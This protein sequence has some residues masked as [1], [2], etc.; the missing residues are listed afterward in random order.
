MKRI[1]AAIFDR[2]IGFGV[3]HFGSVEIV[4][5]GG[6]IQKRIRASFPLLFQHQTDTFVTFLLLQFYRLDCPTSHPFEP[7]PPP[8]SLLPSPVSHIADAIAIHYTFFRPVWEISYPLSLPQQP[9]PLLTV[10]LTGHHSSS[11]GR[12]LMSIRN[13]SDSE[14]LRDGILSYFS[15][16]Y[17]WSLQ[18]AL[19]RAWRTR[20][21]KPVHID[22]PQ[23]SVCI[24]TSFSAV[25][26]SLLSLLSFIT[27]LSLIESC[28]PHHSFWGRAPH[29]L[30]FCLCFLLQFFLILFVVK[31][32]PKLI[33]SILSTKVQLSSMDSTSL[34]VPTQLMATL[35][36]VTKQVRQTSFLLV[37]VKMQS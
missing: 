29:S 25:Q 30:L 14:T 13:S 20:N 8:W 31:P 24:S 1:S 17:Q 23:V 3:S 2:S 9:I 18:P 35:P 28:L 11:F 26:T 7:Q 4:S 33:K 37:Q 22:E 32:P 34:T 21:A 36:T 10:V 5:A 16:V 19:N 6:A 27:Q 12:I 15:S